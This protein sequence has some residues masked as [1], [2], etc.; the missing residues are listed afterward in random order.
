M[1]ATLLKKGNSMRLGTETG[2]LMNHVMGST[3]ATKPE[4]G[5]GATLLYWT[6]RH[7]A[8]IVGVSKSGRVVGVQRDKATRIDSNGMSDMQD[9]SY[10]RDATATVQWFS[11]RKNGSYVEVGTKSGTR[12]GIN[13]RREYYDHSF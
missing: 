8:T 6:D 11:L 10:E 5:M 13:Y 9:Y 3:P 7:A 2:S 1:E 4:P 12:L